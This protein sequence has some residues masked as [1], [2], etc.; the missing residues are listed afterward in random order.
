VAGV[1]MRLKG[2]QKY[3]GKLPAITDAVGDIAVVAFPAPA[4]EDQ[5]VPETGRT[6]TTVN[7]QS[8]EPVTVRSVLINPK[9]K[10]NITADF[11]VSEDGQT[12][13]TLK[14]MPVDRSNIALNVGFMPLAPVVMAIPPTAGRYFR[15]V[16][17]K[18]CELGA[19]QVSS[20]LRVESVYEKQ[21]AKMYPAPMPT[22]NYYT[23]PEPP[24]A[25]ETGLA[26]S[27]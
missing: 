21:L 11:Q 2:P 1:E 8:A 5:A 26:I 20:A 14:T 22:P 24:K 25:D 10:F 7:F 12:Y 18:P 27:P 19:I 23:W 6:P 13:R 4:F 3:S 16:F 15:L 17:S 9:D